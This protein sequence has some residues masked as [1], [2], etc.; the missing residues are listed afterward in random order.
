MR[1]S[2][3]KVGSIVKGS[4]ARFI[5]ISLLLISF[6]E[7]DTN[8]INSINKP[9]VIIFLNICF[10][11]ALILY[12]YFLVYYY[13]NKKLTKLKIFSIYLNNYILSKIIFLFLLLVGT[14]PHTPTSFV[15]TGEARLW[16]EAKRLHLGFNLINYLTCKTKLVLFST[17][18]ILALF[19]T[20]CGGK[21]LTILYK[22]IGLQS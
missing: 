13:T 20:F 5:T 17:N 9:A 19:A 10:S 11:F 8:T 12:F 21:K 15:A 18:F 16:R 1:L 22:D 2:V 6:F 4:G 3:F 14:S 7:Q